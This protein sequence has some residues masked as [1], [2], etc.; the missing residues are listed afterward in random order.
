[1]PGL[2]GDSGA[3]VSQ[4]LVKLP[5]RLNPHLGD[6]FLLRDTRARVRLRRDELHSSH[7]WSVERGI[8]SRVVESLLSSQWLFS[9]RHLYLH[10]QRVHQGVWCRDV[11]GELNNKLTDKFGFLHDWHE[12]E[13]LELLIGVH[14]ILT[15][16]VD[17]SS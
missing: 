8:V 11:L 13:W 16:V 17:R 15:N 4:N 14:V 12:N 9:Q 5:G 6:F 2:Q 10:L 3:D 7:G 1:M